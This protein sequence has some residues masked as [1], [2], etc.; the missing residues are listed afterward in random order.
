M[1]I[2]NA[3]RG[4]GGGQ[5]V[6][7]RST[8]KLQTIGK[9]RKFEPFG[10]PASPNDDNS[11][12]PLSD[13]EDEDDDW[14]KTEIFENELETQMPDTSKDD[15]SDDL[16]EFSVGMQ[17]MLTH[18]NSAYKNSDDNYTTVSNKKPY[19][20]ANATIL[21]L[22]EM[23]KKDPD[24]T[25]VSTD[26]TTK[27]HQPS[28]IP[29]DKEKFESQFEVT[30]SSI[31]IKGK[32]EP[33]YHVS[34]HILTTGSHFWEDV[35]EA[36]IPTLTYHQLF[37]NTTKLEKAT[38]MTPLGIIA[39]AHPNYVHRDELM[40][41]LTELIFHHG[42]KEEDKTKFET[43]DDGHPKLCL[44]CNNK[45]IISEKGAKGNNT[46][47]AKAIIIQAP[48][49]HKTIIADALLRL[50]ILN[51]MPEKMEFVP[52]RMQRDHPAVFWGALKAHVKS[53]NNKTSINIAGLSEEF[54]DE[55]FEHDGENTTAR[56][57]F[58]NNDFKLQTT[59]KSE[60]FGIYRIIC[61]ANDLNDNKRKAAEL[62]RS[63]ASQHPKQC[64][65]RAIT[66]IIR[67][68]LNS[69]NKASTST[70]EYD[71]YAIQAAQKY[72][73]PQ[74]DGT[75]DPSLNANNITMRTFVSQRSYA[76]VTAGYN[77]TTNQPN[78]SIDNANEHQISEFEKFKTSFQEQL[79]AIYTQLET[80][81]RDSEEQRQKTEE[82]QQKTDQQFTVVAQHLTSSAQA[83]QEVMAY[84]KTLKDNNT[85]DKTAQSPQRKIP[86][87]QQNSRDDTEMKSAT[88]PGS[89][90]TLSRDTSTHQGAT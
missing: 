21:L 51:K 58:Q 7:R 71:E 18:T 76:N 8:T 26:K 28:M 20:P 56:K 16:T 85:I 36:I 84:F 24:A 29:T 40:H 79:T 31:N 47:E 68:T 86:R 50:N 83:M 10:G 52:F 60:S 67:L 19:G 64:G 23:K 57:L 6:N 9:T 78:N 53:I 74:D 3:G 15:G 13:N 38:K 1:L 42:L 34:L 25:I 5:S 65:N 70:P 69:A 82:Q 89:A 11:F 62:C 17:G 81:K 12:M 41:H 73:N 66:E 37:V 48:E 49:K 27:Y 55:Q 61:D 59:D 4:R 45:T 43:Y 77:T 88:E 54:L 22:T 2:A 63:I 35:K 80:L 87:K 32:R 72:A 90:V 75:T 46:I 30:Q 33:S 14:G 44:E 39:H